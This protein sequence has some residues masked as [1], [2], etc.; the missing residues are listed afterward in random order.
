MKVGLEGA[1]QAV[2]P[3]PAGDLSAWRDQFLQAFGTTEA[4]IAE[5]LFNQLINALQTDPAKPVSGSTANLALAL[6]HRLAPNNEVEAML[7]VQLVL[8]HFSSMDTSRRGLHADQ[9]AGGRQAYLGLARK[10][11]ALFT[12]QVETLNRL[13]GKTVVQKVIVERVNV[14][15]GGKALVGAVSGRSG[16]PEDG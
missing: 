8:A 1:P 14:E 6:L 5:A 16:G 7:C 11:M 15:A 4:T 9:S 2:A 13:R 10:L 3:D 12:T